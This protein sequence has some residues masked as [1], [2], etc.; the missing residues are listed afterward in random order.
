[1]LAG[2]EALVDLLL[3]LSSTSSTSFTQHV[4]RAADVASPSS[5]PLQ[6]T[7]VLEAGRPGGSL[8][9]TPSAS[10]GRLLMR[11]GASQVLLPPLW[12]PFAVPQEVLRASAAGSLPPDASAALLGP[13]PL[14]CAERGRAFV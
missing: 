11:E 1:M 12:R 14:H 7:N 13:H 6:L 9:S 3:W 4:T 10:T 8:L 2:K 5:P